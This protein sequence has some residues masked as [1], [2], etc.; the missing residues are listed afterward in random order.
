MKLSILGLALLIVATPFPA[1][2][3]KLD[4]AFVALKDAESRKD[5][6]GV[7]QSATEAY[8]A[9]T[10]VIK[11]PVPVVWGAWMNAES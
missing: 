9:A 5:A 8:S 1:F 3:G 7:K 2:P 11:A 6:A 10:E 4:D